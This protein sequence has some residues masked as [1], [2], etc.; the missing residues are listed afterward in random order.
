MKPLALF[1]LLVA[2]L[3][4]GPTAAASGAYADWRLVRYGNTTSPAGDPL[5]QPAGQAVANLLF[6][7][8]G[9]DL[10][11]AAAPAFPEVTPTGLSVPAVAGLALHL[12]AGAPETVVRNG[13]NAVVQ[14]R[15]RSG[16]DIVFTAAAGS[17][18]WVEHAVN[19]LPAIRFDGAFLETTSPAALSMT[20]GAAGFT[21]FGV[22]RNTGTSDQTLFRIGRGSGSTANGLRIMLA[23][24]AIQHRML[25][26]RIDN[27][28]FASVL[29]GSGTISR[30]TWG[31]DSGVVD[32]TGDSASLFINGQRMAVRS[33]LLGSPG[34]ASATDSQM[35]RIGND[36]ESQLWRGDIAEILMYDRALDEGE[37]RALNFHLANKYRIGDAQAAASGS[38]LTFTRRSPLV[39][40]LIIEGTNALLGD[41]W[42]ELAVLEPEAS[43][44]TGPA[45]VFEQPGP[46]GTRRVTMLDPYPNSTGARYFR[47]RATLPMSI[48]V[49]SRTFLH[50][51]NTSA[52]TPVVPMW[53][54]P[55]PT[56]AQST[57][58]GFPVLTQA[59]HTR[60]WGPASLDDGAF[61]HYAALYHH[62]GRFFAMWANQPFGEDAPGQR[63]LFAMSDEWGVW[64]DAAELFP[65]PGPVLPRSESGIHLKADRWVVVNNTLYAV[66]YVHGAGIYPIARSVAMNGALGSPLVVRTSPT[67]SNRPVYM[68][69]YVHTTPLANLATQIRAWYGANDQVSWW[70]R[71]GEGVPSTSIDGATLIESFT[72]RAPDGGYVLFL[73]NWGHNSNPVHNNRLYVSFSNS[74]TSWPTPY[75]TDIPDSPSRA[76]AIKLAN[77]T[78]LLIGNQN[79]PEFDLP[80]Y[81]NRDPMT[82]A[83]SSDGLNFDRVYALR[84]G[85]PTSFRFA[86][87]GGRNYGFA[88]SSSLVLD[89]WLY[90]FYSTGKEDMEITRVP[91]S[92]MGL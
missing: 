5:H 21:G 45:P 34:P 83:I 62:N 88:Y 71:S 31:V 4:H 35:F 63:I 69:D 90:T 57:G 55:M 14:W 40:R 33:P 49:G 18:L 29:S 16:R 80:V 46:E 70:A 59:E 11:P 65:A 19:G 42:Q 79:T 25:A 12:D 64:T 36:H 87:V 85:A 8:L 61:N 76:Q 91:L 2:M 77:G 52:G 84:T 48:M 32:F 66:V 20:H 15:D 74:L 81:L 38:T 56:S 92:A 41:A 17:P 67:A 27:G 3:A 72:Y 53:K 13:G 23:R 28:D 51:T 82:V 50:L 39:T 78:I 30:D 73:R 1:T 24:T 58:A 43:L 60:V 26:R 44:W 75:P 86:G 47:V 10:L 54:A 37:I 9:M 6:H 22:A 7:A 89:G 68:A